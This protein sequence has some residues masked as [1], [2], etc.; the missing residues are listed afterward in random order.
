MKKLALVTAMAAVIGFTVPAQANDLTFGELQTIRILA[1]QAVGSALPGALD[2]QRVGILSNRSV[3]CSSLTGGLGAGMLGANGD[4][5]IVFES[6][7]S[8]DDAAAAVARVADADAVYLAFGGNMD[9]TDNVAQLHQVLRTMADAEW[10][11]TIV[12]HLTTWGQNQ[13]RDIVAE[14]EVVA[15]YLEGKDNVFTATLDLANSEAALQNVS[16]NGTEFELAE[17]GRV[18]LRDD[19]VQLFRRML[20]QA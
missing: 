20:G 9:R 6:L 11:G 15:S 2:A 19:L 4:L 1:G 7:A 17:V 5:D 16:F 10:A 12:I 18:P 14:D 8:P 3:I 13:V